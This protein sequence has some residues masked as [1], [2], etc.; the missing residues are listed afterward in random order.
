MPGE[1]PTH[2]RR[3]AHLIP[4][5]SNDDLPP[6]PDGLPNS[7]G[8]GLETLIRF[9]ELSSSELEELKSTPS[10]ARAIALMESAEAYLESGA[11]AGAEVSAEVSAEELYA[12]GSGP[13]AGPLES[14]R[15]AAVQSHLSASPMEQA[16]V[17]GLKVA[18]PSPLVLDRDAKEPIPSIADHRAQ[19]TRPGQIRPGLPGSTRPSQEAPSIPAPSGPST[20]VNW[21]VWSPLAAAALVLAMALG[22]GARPSTLD[23][24]L[25][26]SPILR[27]GAHAGLLFPKG[28]VLSAEAPSGAFAARPLFEITPSAGATHF[29][30]ELRMLAP[31]NP[32]DASS[33]LFEA[34]ESL[35]TIES[36]NRTITS[37]PLAR[38]AYEW[39]AWETIDGVDRELGTMSFQVVEDPAWNASTLQAEGAT[40]A[41]IRERVRQLHANG[42]L[43]DARS[44]V[45][46]LPDTSE[47]SSYLRGQ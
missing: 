31:T 32:A 25:P 9:D 36:K 7:Q 1:S 35:W 14:D 10:A 40:E 8:T 33:A 47:R 12:Y 5:D 44:L 4:M 46:A 39:T 20:G 13:G 21:M 15:H 37:N 3:A 45:R 34:G 17:D 22:G 18:P 29:R 2:L 38:G 11:L 6:A 27:S 24:A 30:Y 41:V 43:T 23:G 42:Y 28:R 19:A 16:W 26:D